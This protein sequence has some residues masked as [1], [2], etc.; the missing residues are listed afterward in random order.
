MVLLKYPKA[1]AHQWQH[2]QKLSALRQLSIE[3]LGVENYHL[4][5]GEQVHQHLYAPLSLNESPLEYRDQFE[6]RTGR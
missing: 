3:K 5:M 4:N 6:T 2:Y 1:T